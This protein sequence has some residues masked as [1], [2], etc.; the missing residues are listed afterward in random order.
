MLKQEAIK[1]FL[2]SSSKPDLADLF[3]D[4]MECQVNVI[5]GNPIE[6]ESKGHKWKGFTDGKEVWKPIRIPWNAKDP[7][8]VD[9]N[10]N[11]L[12]F[13][14][15]KFEAIGMTGWNY[16]NRESVWVGYD[17][18]SIC[19]HSQGLND[20]DLQSIR[21]NI[22][23]VP[24]VTIRRSTSGKG[25]HF[26]I[27]L[28]PTIE[29]T[30]HTEHAALARALLGIL[31]IR[32]GIKLEAKVDTCG[33]IL[34]IWHRKQ[35]DDGYTLIRQGQMLS[36]VPANW[37]EHTQVISRTR[38]KIKPPLASGEDEGY[39]DDLL[40]KT[41]RAPLDDD[42]RK[43][44]GWLH[45]K[46]KMAWWDNDRE[47]LVSHTF[48]LQQANL[49]LQLKGPF[50]TVSTGKESG[51]DQN[52][53]AYPL[54]NG[55]WAVFR[56]TRKTPEHPCWVVTGGGW[57]RAYLNI[58]A[59]LPTA[60]RCHNGIERSDGRFEFNSA[61]LAIRALADLGATP[62]DCDPWLTSRRCTLRG[63]KEN[64]AV[65]AIDSTSTDPPP[66]GWVRNKDK[67]ERI[68]VI[69]NETP[70]V[71]VPDQFVR[72]LISNDTDAGWYL[73][74]R[75]QWVSE[76]ESNIRK[77][78]IASGLSPK[79]A[80][81]MGGQ[82]VLH[83]WKLVT[84]PFKP[85]YPGDRT[86][87]KNAP[88]YAYSADEAGEY[89]TWQKILDHCGVG[90]DEGVINNEWCL[91]NKINKG[92]DYLAL[93]CAS[94][95]QF[96]HE[97]LPYLFFFGPQN[98]GKSTLHESLAILFKN[99]I[100]Y[101]RADVALTSQARFNA[102]LINAVL[103][104]IEETNLQRSPDAYNRVKDWVTSKTVLIHEKG[105]TPYDVPN[106]THWIQV[107]N[108]LN[109]CPV[110][111]GDTRI[112]MCRIDRPPQE[113]PKAV[114]FQNLEIEAPYFL[115][116]ILNLEVPKTIERLR[117][118]CLATATKFELELVSEEPV[119]DFLLSRCHLI[120]GCTTPL[121]DLYDSFTSW[122]PI[123]RRRSWTPAKFTHNLP[124]YMVTGANEKWDIPRGRYKGVHSVG[125]LSLNPNAERQ[126][127]LIRIFDK[128][129]EEV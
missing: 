125:N 94:M 88:Q 13:G 105:S 11:E 7:E 9:Y 37:K 48:D 26:Y 107:A 55:G 78:M 56:H 126:I 74:V 44:I 89:P 2:Q 86:W 81:E 63:H 47:L 70:E 33:G 124:Q 65:I 17:F 15:D 25:L 32:I 85:E 106:T 10:D 96:P 52:C 40:S 102:E 1:R 122:L 3:N 120:Q 87:N 111:S 36:D 91:E 18:D 77:A 93:W 35:S 67:W 99:K 116:Y 103:C 28:N 45:Q 29:T 119:L 72:H 14:T 113:I 8:K 68:V 61:S 38:N 46:N 83:P 92:S 97:P 71:E 128:L 82:C 114:L 50:Y 16:V 123:D 23:Q 73:Y 51:N 75:N 100:G 57:T 27:F 80:L 121:K 110:F 115:N 76:C 21:H 5:N 95:F 58:P 108:D 19:N 84:Q 39:L 101:I 34:W 118:P 4:Q 41:K 112:V 30:S 60:A 42:H 104:I 54:R 20:S 69:N 22:E 59:D 127:R 66:T 43:L 129:V 64:R 53:F 90:L 6:G 79:Q 24:W 109:Y 98:T 31:S 117:I 49:E 62:F 12:R